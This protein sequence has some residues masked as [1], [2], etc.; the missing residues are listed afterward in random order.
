MLAALLRAGSL[1][2]DLAKGK[3]KAEARKVARQLAVGAATL[4]FLL[5]AF[6]F[7]LAAFAVWLAH[8]IGVVPALGFIG[9]GFLVIAL[10]VVGIGAIAD[11]RQ[12][13][14]PPPPPIVSAVREEFAAAEAADA[15]AG[16]TIGAM[17][18]VAMLA[19]LFARQLSR[20]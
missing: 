4:L 3:A 14:K 8:L 19:Y 18:M 16:S 10:L 9:L 5:L 15:A 11:K 2:V 6:S 20:K 13:R 17:G 12:N 7:G 1:G